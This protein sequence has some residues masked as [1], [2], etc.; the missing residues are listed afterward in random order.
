MSASE[1]LLV[2]QEQL[3][4]AVESASLAVYSKVEKRVTWRAVVIATL[5][6]AL[7]SSGI[8]ITVT[9]VIGHEVGKANT[10]RIAE[11]QNSRKSGTILACEQQNLR[12]EQLY[13]QIELSAGIESV[14]EPVKYKQTVKKARELEAIL[15][16][17]QPEEDC[18]AR[19]KR[20]AVETLRTTPAPPKPIRKPGPLR[21]PRPG[22]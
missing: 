15:D 8:S 16:A 2:T 18:K 11:V 13:L 21:L 17:V 9:L 7:V 12:H 5:V 20:L 4:Q 22:G 14:K 10:D 3:N 19:A 6:S 1:P